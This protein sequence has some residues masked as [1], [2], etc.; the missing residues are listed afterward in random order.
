MSLDNGDRIRFCCET[1]SSTLRYKFATLGSRTSLQKITGKETLPLETIVPSAKPK[2]SRARKQP[3][4]RKV[5]KL[6]SSETLSPTCNTQ[7]SSTS[8]KEIPVASPLANPVPKDEEKQQLLTKIKVLTNELASK[9]AALRLKQQGEKSDS[10]RVVSSLSEE[11]TC[12]ICRELF[13]SAHTLPCSHSFCEYCV[14]EWMT[15]KKVCPVC[16]KKTKSGPVFSLA[17]DNAVSTIE[18]KLSADEK[19]ERESLKITRKSDL[20]RLLESSNSYSWHHDSDSESSSDSSTFSTISSIS[21]FSSI[22]SM[23]S[24]FDYGSD[25][26]SYDSYSDS[27]TSMSTD[28]DDYDDYYDRCFN[29]GK[30]VMCDC[31]CIDVHL[32]FFC[33]GELGHWRRE[34]PYY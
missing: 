2:T 22:S 30:L 13:I 20:Q 9:D 15:K 1:V 33:V 17:L 19:K 8:A 11:F 27:S 31:D 26:D 34:C 10:G 12:I 14:K 5:A 25:Y 24:M 4:A 32:I 3:P 28:S 6:D 21:T 7:S 18:S 23:S 16:R 29:C